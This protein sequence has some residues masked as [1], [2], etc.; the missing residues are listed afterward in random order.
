MS[1]HNDSDPGGARATRRDFLTTA[2]G[3]ASTLAVAQAATAPSV[4]SCPSD[5]PAQ[6][7]VAQSGAPLQTI[8]EIRRETDGVLRAT[9]VVEDENR[10]LWMGKPNTV[11]KESFSVPV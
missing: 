4:T 6:E 10:S 7:G 11:D 9:I 1:S 5:A 3:A 2:L 8:G